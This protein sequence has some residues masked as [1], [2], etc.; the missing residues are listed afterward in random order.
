MLT[1]PLTGDPVTLLTRDGAARCDECSGGSYAGAPPARAS[2][3][4]LDHEVGTCLALDEELALLD[5]DLATAATA[6][7]EL[8]QRDPRPAGTSWV[9]IDQRPVASVEAAQLVALGHIVDLDGLV[10]IRVADGAR[11]RTFLTATGVAVAW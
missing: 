7:A 2:L 4:P 9:V 10:T 3:L 11:T 1:H 6:V 5:S 8:H